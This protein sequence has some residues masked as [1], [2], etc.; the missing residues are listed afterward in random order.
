MAQ[1]A[2]FNPHLLSP[3]IPPSP[4]TPTKNKTPPRK[5]TRTHLPQVLA[6][7]QEPL[8]NVWWQEAEKPW[9]ALA[10]CYEIAGA[11]GV[12]A[13]G[14]GWCGLMLPYRARLLKPPTPCSSPPSL[15]L[16]LCPS[17]QFNPYPNPPHS[18]PTQTTQPKPKP[19]PNPNPNPPNPD[20][21]P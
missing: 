19:N 21:S 20:P 18:T 15:P 16:P 7:A 11:L 5:F 9:Q 13:C 6:C 4:P 2:P 1:Q 17:L 14:L 3:T 8:R 12:S 10:C